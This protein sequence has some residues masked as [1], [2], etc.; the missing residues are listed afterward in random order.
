MR[1]KE[2]RDMLRTKH[3]IAF[4]FSTS[5]YKR[6]RFQYFLFAFK[7]TIEIF[8]NVT[9]THICIFFI[10]F[11]GWDGDECVAFEAA[12][13]PIHLVAK[14]P[15]H[16]IELWNLFF[17]FLFMVSICKL[18]KQWIFIWFVFARDSSDLCLKMPLWEEWIHFSFWCVWNKKENNKNNYNKRYLSIGHFCSGS[19]IWNHIQ[20]SFN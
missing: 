20:M 7:S 3:Q 18:N 15:C 4:A 16:A 17:G 6:L 1:Y 19:S 14:R 8:I 10:E 9:H 13:E 11:T 5:E 12:H 2:K